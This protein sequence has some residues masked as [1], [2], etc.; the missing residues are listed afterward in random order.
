MY[1]H[2]CS[3]ISPPPYYID[4]SGQ[5]GSIAAF[6]FVSWLADGYGRRWAIFIGCIIVCIGTAIQT[7]ANTSM[8]LT[9]QYPDDSLSLFY[10]N[11][12]TRSGPIPSRP[13][14]SRV[15]GRNS[16]RCS[17]GLR[18]RDLAPG[19]PRDASRSLQCLLV[20]R[21][22]QYALPNQIWDRGYMP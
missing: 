2:F 10:F 22:D 11:H 4:Q 14:R 17:T 12:N 6:P 20:S 21:I 3:G 18:R 15:W 7:P 16:R 8:F 5:L 19:A 9:I 13:V 1:V